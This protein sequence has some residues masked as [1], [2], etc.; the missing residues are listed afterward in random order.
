MARELDQLQPPAGGGLEG[1]APPL[2]ASAPA[3]RHLPQAHE[4]QAK[5][6]RSFVEGD[7]EFLRG[8]NRA[9]L[10]A[11]MGR[12]DQEMEQEIDELRQRYQA[13]RQPI[14]DAMDHK[15]KRQHNF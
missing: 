10:E 13:K 7:F 1:A 11:R 4:K 15:R 6:Q 2:P 14:L 8:L 9:E 5:F 12:L 3:P